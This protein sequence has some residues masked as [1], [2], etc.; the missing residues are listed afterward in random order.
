MNG[1]PQHGPTALAKVLIF[2]I[3]G[4]SIAGAAYFFKD[5]LF[6]GAGHR[7]IDV[8]ADHELNQLVTMI[9]EAGDPRVRSDRIENA[10]AAVAELT[11]ARTGNVHD[12]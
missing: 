11:A 7:D 10:V 6:P 5:T 12:R 9:T 4:A 3:I 2:L 8:I 1:E